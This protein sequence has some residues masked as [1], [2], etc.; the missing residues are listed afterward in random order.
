MMRLMEKAMSV[1]E[2]DRRVNSLEGLSYRMLQ[3]QGLEWR[4]RVAQ[5]ATAA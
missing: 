1:D 3:G 2:L 4:A 5:F